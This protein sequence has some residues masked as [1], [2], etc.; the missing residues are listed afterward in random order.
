MIYTE[1]KKTR[2][3][4]IAILTVVLL[5]VF[6]SI[7]FLIIYGRKITTSGDIVE[8]GII[9]LTTIPEDVNVYIN[10]V[11]FSK[12][13]NIVQ[14]VPLGEIKVTLEKEG[15]KN[16][17]KNVIIEKGRVEEIFAQ[18]FPE[19]L[20]LE[21]L[22]E[23]NISKIAFD[24]T[25]DNAYF[26]TLNS[27]IPLEKGLWKLKLNR[28]IL[29]FN[30]DTKPEKVAE[31]TDELANNLIAEDYKIEVSPDSNKLFVNIPNLKQLL[32][33]DLNSANTP[34]NFVEVAGFYPIQTTWFDNS[35]VLL[36]EESDILFTYNLSNNKKEIIFYT[37]NVNTQYCK[38]GE[39]VYF[40]NPID[41][42]FY[43]FNSGTEEIIFPLLDNKEI[44]L[45]AEDK[46]KC[47]EDEKVVVISQNNA[48]IYFN[49]E[50]NFIQKVSEKA[51]VV[52]I[53]ANGRNLLL[54][55]DGNFT[56]VTFEVSNNLI[57]SRSVNIS[58]LENIL[59]L[60]YSYSSTALVKIEKTIEENLFDLEIAD[61]EGEN[62]SEILI[63]QNF[64]VD[65]TKLSE[66]NTYLYFAL[67]NS[68]NTE[69]SNYNLY[70]I[71]LNE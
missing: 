2:S 48:N 28:G 63:S 61:S 31:F 59:S 58:N 15:F 14:N 40:I 62:T 54:N 34:L 38:T 6:T 56:A 65:S 1:G 29:D 4:I 25:G 52:D 21:Q 43:E 71:K 27:E 16:W 50:E 60:E 20:K 11:N 30:R 17:S 57:N 23:L 22:S 53:S 41:N 42:K 70:R 46:L 39:N 69:Q 8:L 24:K 55:N 45:S 12:S 37:P 13:G 35:N 68:L 67:N 66:D 26:L 64:L 49:L 47:A 7:V 32:I 51:E 36:V 19:E 33:F 3:Y 9:R 10:G 5:V 18:L 44:I